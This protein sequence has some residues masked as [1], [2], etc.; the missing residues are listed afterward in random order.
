[1]MLSAR[2]GIWNEPLT[3][4]MAKA[5]VCPRIPLCRLVPK[6]DSCTAANARRAAVLHWMTLSAASRPLGPRGRIDRISAGRVLRRRE[7]ISAHHDDVTF[8]HSDIWT[9]A[10]T[11]ARL[12]ETAHAREAPMTMRRMLPAFLVAAFALATDPAQA[13]MQSQWIE[14]THGDTKLKAYLDRKST[15]LNSSHLGIS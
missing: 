9:W 3:Q 1:M 8:I 14:Y 15:R 10:L 13:E 5:E 2:P 7:T 12:S 4:A 6:P 11:R